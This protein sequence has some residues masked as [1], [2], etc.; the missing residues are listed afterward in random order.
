MQNHLQYQ[1]PFPS[2]A[3][4]A[5]LGNQKFNSPLH[6]KG[7]DK[8]LPT[9]NI[10]HYASNPNLSMEFNSQ[11]LINPSSENNIQSTNNLKKNIEYRSP[12]SHHPYNF[13]LNQHTRAGR[14]DMAKSLIIGENSNVDIPE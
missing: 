11:K 13:N 12:P 1:Q 4:T 10:K 3:N 5:A 2:P 8:T 9:P 7:F 6:P 14:N